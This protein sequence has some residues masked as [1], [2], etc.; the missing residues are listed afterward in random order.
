MKH[1]SFAKKFCGK[2]AGLKYGKAALEKSPY[3]KE[4]GEKTQEEIRKL[5]NAKKEEETKPSSRTVREGYQVKGTTAY[6][7]YQACL[8]AG[9]TPESCKPP[10][11]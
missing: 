1:S 7:K 8:A 6:K 4:T 11:T 9:G 10:G 5:P 2:R 3:M